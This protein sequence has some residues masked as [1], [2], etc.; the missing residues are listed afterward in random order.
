[1]Y[2]ACAAFFKSMRVFAL[3]SCALTGVGWGWGEGYGAKGNLKVKERPGEKV[4]G[5]GKRKKEYTRL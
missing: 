3:F 5:I 4:L 2:Y 1:M